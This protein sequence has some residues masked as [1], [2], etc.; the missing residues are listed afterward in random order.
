MRAPDWL[1][2]C[3]VFLGR[4]DSGEFV[5]YGTGF[6]VGKETVGYFF[7]HIVTARHVI[8]AIEHHE[9]CV[10]INQLNG[11]VLHEHLPKTG[12]EVH[13]DKAVDIAVAPATVEEEKYK[14]SNVLLDRHPL[15]PEV[16]VEHDIGVGE[17]VIT[18][19]M[20]TRHIG[21]TSN[22]PIVR[23][24]II[25]AMPNE[26]VETMRG[27]VI[28][29]LVEVRSIGGLS[30]SPVFVQMAPQRV[31]SNGEVRETEGQAYYFLGVMLGHH[32]TNDPKEVV[33]LD[34]WAPADMNTGLG[35]V[36]PWQRLMEVIEM[37]VLR[38]QR[39]KIAQTQ[40]RRR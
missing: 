21:L 7:Q 9:V 5:S 34:P 11:S 30:G 14:I 36:V 38:E 40:I 39:E 24:G 20:F 29:Y 35:V 1:L 6:L 28:A 4:D 13:P 17:D 10:R 33:S 3:I 18:A 16:I 37:P 31:L 19:G 26:P 8:E 12:W 2:N 22:R 23:A 27:P 25:S 32:V 15:T